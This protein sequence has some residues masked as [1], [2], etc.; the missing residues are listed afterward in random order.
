MSYN[1]FYRKGSQH[2]FGDFDANGIKVQVHVLYDTPQ[3]E[4][5]PGTATIEFYKSPFCRNRG[6]N[7]F[8]NKPNVVQV[9]HA[10]DSHIV[11]AI[12][13]FFKCNILDEIK[14]VGSF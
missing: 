1:V 3:G 11:S 9:P 7:F 13:G 12:N 10:D 14:V 8:K 2:I 6:A 4:D 5:R